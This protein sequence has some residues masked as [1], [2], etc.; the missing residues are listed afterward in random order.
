MKMADCVALIDARQAVAVRGP[1]K[2]RVAGEI[3]N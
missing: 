2:K 3:S 1:Y